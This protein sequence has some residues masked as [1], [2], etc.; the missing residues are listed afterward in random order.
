MCWSYKR[1]FILESVKMAVNNDDKNL[2]FSSTCESDYYSND[3]Y[4]VLN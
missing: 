2:Y 3:P 4:F 1:E